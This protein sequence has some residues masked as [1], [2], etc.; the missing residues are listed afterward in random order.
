MNTVP[1]ASHARSASNSVLT[2]ISFSV[3]YQVDTGLIAVIFTD[4]QVIIGVGL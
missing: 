1:L 2:R 3:Y 4:L